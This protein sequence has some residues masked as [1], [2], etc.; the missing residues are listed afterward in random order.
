MSVE[1]FKRRFGEVLGKG[2]KLALKTSAEIVKLEHSRASVPK[3]L[4]RLKSSGWIIKESL[5]GARKPQVCI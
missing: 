3:W 1:Y 5:V 4:K 2:G